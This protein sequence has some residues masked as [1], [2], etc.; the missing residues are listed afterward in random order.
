[1]E[2][3]YIFLNVFKYYNKQYLNNITKVFDYS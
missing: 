2:Y 3:K 1:M